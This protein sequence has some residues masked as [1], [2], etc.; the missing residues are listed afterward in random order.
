MRK[1]RP[2]P[3]RRE[4]ADVL[5]LAR[6]VG[7]Q[8]RMAHRA[9]QRYLQAKI[10]PY[11]VTPGM[12]YFLRA[13]WNEDGL[14]QSELSRRIGTMEPTTLT[15]IAAMERGGLVT[16]VRSERDRRKQHVFLTERGRALKRELL[17]LAVEVVDTATAGFSADEV[18]ALL[19]ALSRIQHNLDAALSDVAGEA[20][21]RSAAP[22]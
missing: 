20:V 2:D 14:T 8:V 9:L 13:L 21:D 5:P 7:Y 18:A 4:A 12:W 19:S 1:S 3:A 17:P 22:G 6:S 16:R 15:A 11:G 10:G